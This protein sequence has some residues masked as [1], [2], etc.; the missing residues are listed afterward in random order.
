MLYKEYE[1]LTVFQ[2]IQKMGERYG[3]RPL[4]SWRRDG[5]EEQ[6]TYGTFVRDVKRLAH[7]FDAL[8]LRGKCV[9]I[10]G[11]NSYEQVTA[12]FAA[13][14][15]GAVAAPICFDLQTEDLR[16]LVDRIAPAVLI[17]D[18]EDETLLPELELPAAVRPL[19]SRGKGGVDA[20]LAEDGPLYE[21]DG[22][23]SPDAP[24]LLMA[25]SGS[26]SRSKLVLLPHHALLPH[27]Q[28]E[29]QR[30][31][32]V[33]PMHHIAGLNILINDMARGIEICLSSLGRG[34]SDMGW[35]SPRDVFAVPSFVALMVQRSRMG[36]LDLSGFASITSGGAPQNP[37]MARY[38]EERGIFS[39]S[40]YGATET[41]GMVDYSTP[42]CYRFGS[43]GRPGPWNEIRISPQGEVLVRGKNVMLGYL[44]D[45]EATAQAMEDGWYHTGDTGRID[46]DGFLYITGRIKNIIVLS[47]GE[48]VSPE[49]V[50]EKLSHCQA[51][52]EVIVRG[53]DDQIVAHIWCGEGAGEDK[54]QAVEAFIA[55][56]NRSVPSYYAIRRTVFRDAPFGRTASG[57]LKRE[58]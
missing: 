26:T 28:V 31:I 54:R 43:V 36:K 8:G 47:N 1:G 56:Y 29:T 10:D 11:R 52:E 12:L 17:Y 37:E 48:N 2:M 51:V 32:F 53:E 34:I 49:A 41:A 23:D 19:P 18:G 16:D 4:F 9:V 39:M 13:A 30:S 45:P 21:G 42:E 46:E 58:S 15:M 3:N 50:E 55:R 20:V 38:L 27:S 7:F 35:F 24:A 57:K 22:G 5:R 6:V 44:D 25:T 40:L 33:L 14:S